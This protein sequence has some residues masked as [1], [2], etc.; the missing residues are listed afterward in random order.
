MVGQL[1]YPLDLIRHYTSIWGN[2]H[3]MINF[4]FIF[5]FSG[6]GGVSRIKVLQIILLSVYFKTSVDPFLSFKLI[7]PEEILDILVQIPHLSF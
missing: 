6:G 7:R 1:K 2:S 5:F 3:S 4:L